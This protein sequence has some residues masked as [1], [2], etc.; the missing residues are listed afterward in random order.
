MLEAALPIPK[1]S[2]KI[3]YILLGTQQRSP[4]LAKEV[5]CGSL[6]ILFSLYLNS[7]QKLL[8]N[9]FELHF[10]VCIPTEWICDDYTDCSDGWDEGNTTASKALKS[11]PLFFLFFVVSNI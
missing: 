5:A 6:W 3:I 8:F 7:Q 1:N 10:Q 9:L 11:M 2:L 4:R